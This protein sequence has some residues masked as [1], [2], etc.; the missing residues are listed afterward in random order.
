MI[1]APPSWSERDYEHIKIVLTLPPKKQV[2]RVSRPEPRVHWLMSWAFVRVLCWIAGGLAGILIA[3][4]IIKSAAAHPSISPHTHRP[5]P[6]M[7]RPGG[8]G[9]NLTPQRADQRRSE[10]AFR[11]EKRR[12]V[13]LER[14]MHR[15]FQLA[16]SSVDMPYG[17]LPMLAAGWGLTAG[18]VFAAY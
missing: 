16:M 3:A 15:K 6:R 11:R 17:P 5:D 9:S 13:T 8:S 12:A 7:A 18:E 2:R 4:L 10:K 1:K 14:I